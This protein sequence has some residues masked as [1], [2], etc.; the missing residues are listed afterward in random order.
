MAMTQKVFYTTSHNFVRTGAGISSR[1]R[2]M[3]VQWDIVGGDHTHVNCFF[4]VYT[5]I[6]IA[7][8]TVC[9]LISL[10]FPINCCL[11]L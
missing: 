1:W 5:I 9:L 3:I 2:S 11:N 4:L 7:A 8:I 6:S 10:L